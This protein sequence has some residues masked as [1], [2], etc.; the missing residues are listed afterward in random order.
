MEDKLLQWFDVHFAAST[1]NGRLQIGYRKKGSNM[2]I[3]LSTHEREQ[4]RH[5]IENMFIRPDYDYYITA[6]SVS[7][8]KRN[9]DSL[10]SYHNIV[11]DIDYHTETKSEWNGMHFLEEEFI[12]RF[13]RD[14]PDQLPNPT[15]M[16]HT[17]RGLQLWWAIKPVH[18]ACKPYFDEVRYHFIEEIQKIVNDYTELSGL[19]VDRAASCNDVGYF[20]LPN[21]MNTKVN[22][23]AEVE[24]AEEKPVYL[25]QDLVAFVKELETNDN[26][27]KSRDHQLVQDFSDHEVFILKNVQTLAF[28]RM[29]QL[30]LLRKI[31]N[32]AVSL[33]TRNNLNFLMYN[34]LLPA[35]G[36]LDAWQK[37]LLFNDGFKEPMTEKE[38]DGVIVSARKKGGYKYTNKKIISFL[39]ISP[40]EQ[41]KIGLFISKTN[42]GMGFSRNPSRNASRALARQAR[43]SQVFKLW[44][45]GMTLSQIA[46]EIGI[47]APTVSKILKF[48]ELQEEKKEKAVNL[49]S[50]GLGV[51][52]VSHQVDL[53]IST[54]KRLKV[55]QKR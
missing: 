52:A 43:D 21:S 5:F 44:N 18:K 11:I 9:I 54:I 40:E 38:L 20:R 41:E 42:N 30:I 29:R 33:E 50:K 8:V 10:F 24:I 53:S 37:L 7:G 1:F 36:E 3:P 49:L 16:V 15:S 6:N 23:R 19:S 47:S 45:S 34:T 27:H 51:T 32:S 31:R 39:E 55:S 22:K 26:T 48:S 12:A 14:K 13:F 25:L 17:G 35:M 28:F 4:L 46:I 2:L